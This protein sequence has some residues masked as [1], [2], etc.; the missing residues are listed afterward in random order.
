MIPIAIGTGI[1]K[2]EKLDYGDYFL[3]NKNSSLLVQRKSMGDFVGSYT[4]L[5][6]QFIGMKTLCNNTA[7]LTEGNYI[8]QIKLY[9]ENAEDKE[10]FL[11]ISWCEEWNDDP[12]K[13]FKEI[14]I[15]KTE[16]P[17]YANDKNMGNLYYDCMY[18]KVYEV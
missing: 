15:S 3:Q 8:I 4:G 7:L 16:S 2:I 5:K 9:S 10:I 17:I 12:E 6:K 11:K 13:M 14:T 18:T 1:Y